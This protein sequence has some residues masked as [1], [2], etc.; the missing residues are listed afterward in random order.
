[1][2]VYTYIYILPF[3]Y[4][5]F[6]ISYFLFPMAFA[7]CLLSTDCLL[8]IAYCLRGL[9]GMAL[10]R[11]AVIYEYIY[12]YIYIYIKKHLRYEKIQGV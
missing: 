7:Y 1:M 5:L 4:C 8:P 3:A 6:H 12:I 10:G 11:E 9:G 2:Y